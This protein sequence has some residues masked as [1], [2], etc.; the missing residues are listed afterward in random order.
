MTADL[1]VS[2]NIARAPAGRA[3][4]AR[5]EYDRTE[6]ALADSPGF[7]GTITLAAPDHNNVSRVI[8]LGYY[9]SGEM[10]CR[11]GGRKETFTGY[12][13]AQKLAGRVVPDNLTS[14]L[15][16]AQQYTGWYQRLDY[17][18]AVHTFTAGKIVVGGTSG[19]YGTIARTQNTWICDAGGNPV[20]QVP[21]SA[22]ALTSVSGTFQDN[23]TIAEIAG[24]GEALVNGTRMQIDHLASV[25]YPQDWITAI[26]GGP[27]QWA[28]ETG[29]CPYRINPVNPVTPGTWSPP[30]YNQ[31]TWQGSVTRQEAIDEL[32][33]YYNFIFYVK[34]M[35]DGSIAHPLAYWVHQDD[36]DNAD[37]DALAEHRGLGLPAPV[38]VTPS[39]PYLA[40]EITVSFRGDTG[41]N[42]VILRGSDPV[43]GTWYENAQVPDSAGNETTATESAGVYYGTEI[44]DEYYDDADSRLISQADV[45]D[46]AA[47]IYRCLKNGTT[48]WKAVF[49]KR[50]DL[51]LL[52]KMTFSGFDPREIPDD[53]YRIIGIEYHLAPAAGTVTVT[54]IRNSRFAASLA[55]SRRSAGAAPATRQAIRAE[56]ATI[57][58]DEAGTV[59]AVNGDAITVQT[60]SGQTRITRSLT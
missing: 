25:M 43:T 36:I 57:A 16:P 5:V 34:W 45:Q 3:W 37:D 46:R 18:N 38:A 49:L 50:F 7:A 19:A 42:K 15:Q 1:T 35:S 14:L 22:L 28:T 10:K 8:F 4:I 58:Q 60:E 13:Y 59:V 27:E 48:T 12:D 24:A 40:G 39:D 32:S 29:C 33:A 30:A 52:Q 6:T 44:P 20:Y 26:L 31:W 41:K 11:P 17:D 54:L 23:E 47:R 21:P 2:V 55:V 9:G 56:L 53:T 51:V